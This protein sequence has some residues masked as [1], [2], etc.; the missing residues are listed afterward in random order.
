[1]SEALVQLNL[2]LV[3]VLLDRE[4]HEQVAHKSFIVKKGSAL[5]KKLVSLYFRES[6]LVCRCVT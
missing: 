5:R 4:W 1:M 3:I 6:Y 2:N